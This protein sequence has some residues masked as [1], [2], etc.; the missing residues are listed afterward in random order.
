[1]K[2]WLSESTSIGPKCAD[3]TY[4]KGMPFSRDDCLNTVTNG[5]DFSTCITDENESL[6]PNL[7]TSQVFS[8]LDKIKDYSTQTRNS[9]VNKINNRPSPEESDYFYDEY[10]DYP[11][12]GTIIDGFNNELNLPLNNKT[13]Y[14]PGKT[15]TIYAEI[16]NKTSLNPSIAKVPTSPFTFFGMPLPAI[17]MGKILNTGR[18]LDWPDKKEH[19][20]S[21]Y[22]TSQP[23]LFETGGF[24]PMLPSTAGG[25]MPIAN[26]S[27]NITQNT[28]S[29]HNHTGST[30]QENTQMSIVGVESKPIKT[31][32]RNT[33]H[34]QVKSEVHE[35]QSYIDANNKTQIAY[36]RTKNLQAEKS[37]PNTLNKYNFMESNI[38]IAEVTEKE[39]PLITTDIANDMALQAW[40][41][42]TTVSYLFSTPESSRPIR[43][44]VDQPTALSAVLMSKHEEILNNFVKRPATITKVNIPHAEQYDMNVYSPVINREA[45]TRFYE[46]TSSSNTKALQD[47]GKEWYYKNYNNSNLEPYVAPGVRMSLSSYIFYNKGS[48]AI[49][50]IGLIIDLLIL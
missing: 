23:P 39:V 8:P 36:N 18:K 3:G 10:V 46:I 26:P 29:V 34:Q 21:R 9:Y 37:A 25:F 31:S 16:K 33:T 2:S 32:Q 38:T 43:K 49:V 30:K 40:I 17:D 27:L 20:N 22:Q 6:L 44:P 45:K 14:T 41:D 15:P 24:T 7:A 4:V 13:Q 47:D 50:S 5:G 12:N 42:T 28:V 48:L 11:Y 1:M 19:R 35:L